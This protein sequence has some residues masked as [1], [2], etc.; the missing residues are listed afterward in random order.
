METIKNYLDNMFLGLPRTK[1]VQRAKEELLSMMEDKYQELKEQGKTENEAIGIVI[2]EF[3]NLEEVAE[4]L[5]IAGYMKKGEGDMKEDVLVLGRED[6]EEYIEASQ[7]QGLRIGLGVM[8][9]ILSPIVMIVLDGVAGTNGGNQ[10]LASVADG[11]GLLILLLFVAAGV[12]LMILGGMT[13]QK[14]EDLKK[15]R[16]MLDYGAEAFVREED[17]AFQGGFAVSIAMGVMLCVLSAVPVSLTGMFGG[18][19][20]AEGIGVGIML[21]LV[22][23]GV[24][25]FIVAGMRKSSYD[26]LLKKGEYKDK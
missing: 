10:V 6:A 14:Y 12:G 11:I 2:S 3:G 4:I 7:R 8:L 9:C 22:G 21:F 23:V 25:L 17:A 19:D 20:L 15:E 13:F 5:G 1:E 16:I 26:F 18:S 24:L